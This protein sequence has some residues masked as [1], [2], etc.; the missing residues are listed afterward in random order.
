MKPVLTRSSRKTSSLPWWGQV[1][2]V[3]GL[4]LLVVSLLVAEYGPVRYRPL[5]LRISS[6]WRP[7]A[8]GVAVLVL[9]HVLAWHP[10]LVARFWY[11]LRALG[12]GF[13]K[14][15]R[16]PLVTDV[17]AFGQDERLPASRRAG[18]IF[19]AGEYLQSG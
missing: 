1:A 11:L 15:A 14:Q 19:G 6:P 17:L 4:A 10:P 9:R 3:A 8:W 16:S 2:D 18:R 7:L 5:G 12:R 13:V